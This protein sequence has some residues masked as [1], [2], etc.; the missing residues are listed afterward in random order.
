MG[1]TTAKACLIRDRA[2]PITDELEVA[3][4]KRFTKSSG[5]PIGMPAVNMIEIGAGGGSIAAVNRL[6]LVQVGPE[7]AGST[8]GPALSSV[9]KERQ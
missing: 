2:L 7:S 1:G 9:V 6:G 3:R 5:Y 4:S 8:P